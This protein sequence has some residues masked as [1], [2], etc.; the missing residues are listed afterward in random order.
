MARSRSTER[1]SRP[2]RV[3]M[4]VLLVLAVLIF[5]RLVLA[6]FGVLAASMTGAWYLTMTRALVP[7]I[8]GGWAVRSPYAGVFSVDAAIVV[9]VLLVAEWLLAVMADSGTKRPTGEEHGLERDRA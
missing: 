8:A 3:V 5:M 9:V 4:D 7:P 1:E 6:F 2:I